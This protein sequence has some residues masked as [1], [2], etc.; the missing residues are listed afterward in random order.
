MKKRWL[1]P[2]G[3]VVPNRG[4]G[5]YPSDIRRLYNIPLNLDGN[6]QTMGILEFS[7]GYR[8]QDALAFWSRHKIVPPNVEFVSVDGTRHTV[9]PN[10]QDAEASLDLQWA[11]ALAPGAKLV[12]YEAN[13]GQTYASFSK[14]MSRTLRYILNQG[15]QRPSVITIS[16]G[17]AEA[18]FG[19]AAL[20]E[21][22]ALISQ[23]AAQGTIVCSASGDDGA[24]GMHI[25]TKR[26]IRR[27]DAPA[28]LPSVVA[29]GGTS[30]H[31]DGVETAWTYHGPKNGGATGGGFSRIFKKPSYQKAF[32]W[33]MRGLPDVA[34]NADPA[35]GYQIVFRGQPIVVGGT[36][37]SSPVFAAILALA[38]QNRMALGLPAFTAMPNWLYEHKNAGFF[39]D[40]VKGNNSFDGVR[41]YTAHRGWDACT[42]YGSMDVTKFVAA[43][44][45]YV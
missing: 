2:D 28:S 9:G 23:L 41:G 26:R 43:A 1:T 33:K 20:V 25:L 36:S 35:Y 13:G 27:A 19:Q 11:G 7:S 30:L 24:Y 14:A 45:Q 39:R 18:S 17:D 12:V 44:S 37:V 5:Y 42:G 8:L 22:D 15:A 40:I 31:P 3:Q 32:S 6:G 10:S 4:Q 29:V 34:F 21:W 16:Y 38:N